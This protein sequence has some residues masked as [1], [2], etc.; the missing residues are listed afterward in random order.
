[1]KLRTKILIFVASC[2]AVFCGLFVSLAYVILLPA[3]ERTEALVMEQNRRRFESRLE[4]RLGGLSQS[5]GDWAYW[6]DA[7]KFVTD[8]NAKFIRENLNAASFKESA[9]EFVMIWDSQDQP[10]VGRMQRWPTE[11]PVVVPAEMVAELASIPRVFQHAPEGEL[12]GLTRTSLG[13]LMLSA[14]PIANSNGTGPVRGTMLVGSLLRGAELTELHAHEPFGVELAPAAEQPRPG[15]WQA[16]AD[17]GRPVLVLSETELAGRFTLPDL[18]TGVA[19]TVELRAP[20]TLYLQQV[21]S[22]HLVLVAVGASSVVL[23]IVVGLLVEVLFLRRLVRLQLEVR[24]LRDEAGIQRL[25]AT[26]GTPEF[27]RL[28]QD[29]AAM[30]RGWREAQLQAEAASQ[31]KGAFLAT[32]SHEIRTPMNGVLGFTSLLRGTA[33]TSEQ[34]EYVTTIEQSGEILLALINDI[35][36]LSKL[37]LHRVELERQPVVLQDLINEIGVLFSPRLRAKGVRLA[38]D[39]AAEVPPAVLADALRLR[40]VMFNLVGNAAKFTQHGEVRV[41][42][43]RMTDAADLT[44][45]TC[46]LCFEIMDTGIGLSE[47]QRVRLFQ[48]FTQA[49]SSTTRQFGGTGLGLAIS[50]RLVSLMG[51]TIGVESQSGQGARFFFSI[52]VPVMEEPPNATALAT[53]VPL[54]TAP[55]YGERIL[56]VEDNVVNRRMISMM[57]SRLHCDADYAEN[58][59]EAVTKAA[60]VDQTYSLVLMDVVMPEMDGLDATRAIRAHELSR[61]LSPVWIVALTASAL[62]GDRE[63]CFS[64]GMNDF[65]SKP[66]RLEEL[67]AV[68][69]RIPP[70]GPTAG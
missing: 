29:I 67:I 45:K 5:G 60:T 13:V 46:S 27:R 59:A 28:G 33:L 22:I 14:Q 61:G 21:Q 16:T 32:M 19:A 6:D 66:F 65:L 10:V 54:Q 57:L 69:D 7:A 40:Q 30:A 51:G 43:S 24:E 42:I 17:D 3:A 26:G 68:L 11:E 50:Q 2:I 25:E 56:V 34:N 8:R 55:R 48:P 15:A 41:R 18:K 38:F 23:M 70:R 47:E 4:T 20:R 63:R 36:D 53:A 1:M 9:I 64:A 12:L 35:L 49:D 44:G 37:E 62:V 31:A 39:C 58:G 52:R